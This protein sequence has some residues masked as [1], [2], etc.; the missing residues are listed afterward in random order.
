MVG[1]MKGNH[2]D[3]AGEEYARVLLTIMGPVERGYK[4]PDADTDANTGPKMNG[5]TKAPESLY[6]F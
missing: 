3:G 1:Y 6:L 2:W 5:D 4:V